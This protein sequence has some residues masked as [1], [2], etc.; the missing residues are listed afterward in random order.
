MGTDMEAV[1]AIPSAVLDEYIQGFV[2][3]KEISAGKLGRITLLFKKLREGSSASAG[4][5]LEASSI[6]P[7]AMPPAAVV[8][9]GQMSQVLDQSD[10]SA[11]DR[12]DPAHRSQ[13]RR[14]Y[15]DTCGG[16]P[17]STVIPPF[18]A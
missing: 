4:V 17:L 10:A 7:S 14:N 8:S 15:F 16:P 13:L 12:L 11:F 2:N 1:A 3:D 6:V 18:K 9:R 5:P